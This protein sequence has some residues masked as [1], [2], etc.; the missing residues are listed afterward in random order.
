MQSSTKAELSL[1]RTV[2]C[3][4]ASQNQQVGN[5]QSCLIYIHTHFITRQ[6]CRISNA[7]MFAMSSC[8]QELALPLPS[9][10]FCGECLFPSR[11]T[12][13]HTPCP[14]PARDGWRQFC[15]LESGTAISLESYT[16][17]HMHFSQAK[18]KKYSKIN[19]KCTCSLRSADAF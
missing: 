15:L 16:Y 3:R 5:F 1:W 2:F 17:Q 12:T 14:A 7:V 4:F 6:C 11:P 19:H 13:G 10:T 9:F 8:Q 18:T